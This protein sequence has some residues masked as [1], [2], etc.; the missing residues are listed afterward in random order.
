MRKTSLF[1]TTAILSAMLAQ[2]AFAQTDGFL[3]MPGS[4]LKF[5]GAA[6]ATSILGTGTSLALE[7]GPISPTAGDVATY[8]ANAQ[9]LD[10]GVTIPSV[11]GT[12]T[13]PSVTFVS[14][15]ATLTATGNEYYNSFGAVKYVNI[16]EVIV[17][18]AAG[19]AT[20]ALQIQLPATESN[21]GTISCPTSGTL[22]NTGTLPGGGTA[23]VGIIN[24]NNAY[25]FFQVQKAAGA[26]NIT[27]TNMTAGTTYTINTTCVVF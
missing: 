26:V 1:N 21:A 25:L 2:E 7:T 4:S 19:T 5:A 13:N 24:P 18:T 27:A 12:I 9:L 23:V 8:G 11:T 3:T 15:T 14:G 20:G 17:F 16:N 10:S 6:A 22:I